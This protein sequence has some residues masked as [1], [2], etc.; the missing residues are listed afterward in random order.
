MFQD[1]FIYAGVP[2]LFRLKNNKEILY[3]KDDAALQEFKKSH[4]VDKY[5][6]S[7]CKG[8]GELSA[9]ETAECL[10]DPNNRIIKRITVEDLGAAGLLFDTLLGSDSTSRKKFIQDNA[11]KAEIYV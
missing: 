6:I 4:S 9:E 8:L 3:L 2:P 11:E 5:Q 10:I 1:G 7:R